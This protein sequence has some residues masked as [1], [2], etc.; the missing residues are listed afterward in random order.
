VEQI[1][2]TLAGERPESG[3]DFRAAF[4]KVALFLGRP[5]SE[6]VLFSGVPFDETSSSRM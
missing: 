5:G 2:G 3:D 4:R 6:T 1:R